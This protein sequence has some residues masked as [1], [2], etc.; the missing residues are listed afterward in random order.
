M[1]YRNLF[2]SIQNI[3]DLC[4][5]QYFAFFSIMYYKS[6]ID[7]EVLTNETVGWLSDSTIFE[8]LRKINTK[9]CIGISSFQYKTSQTRVWSSI[10]HFSQHQLNKF[11][12]NLSSFLIKPWV[13]Y[14]MVPFSKC[15]KKINTKICIAISSFQYNTSQTCVWLS[16]SRFAQ[17]WLNKL[18]LNLSLFLIKPQPG[19][20]MVPFPIF[21][22]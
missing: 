17:Y 6:C 21:Q 20:Q 11:V 9:V 22:G 16:I 19:Y 8:I 12:F 1:F 15:G 14:Q 10:S 5:V 18:V 13:G 7:I 2:I 4:L 3:A